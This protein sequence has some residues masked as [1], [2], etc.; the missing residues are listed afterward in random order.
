MESGS[1]EP[2]QSQDPPVFLAE[3]QKIGKQNQRFVEIRDNQ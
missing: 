3:A 2:I 1:Y